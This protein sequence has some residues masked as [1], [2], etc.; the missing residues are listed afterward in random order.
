MP[1]SNDTTALW[2]K[3]LDAVELG[4]KHNREAVETCVI[5][6]KEASSTLSQH[7]STVEEAVK[8]KVAVERLQSE[9]K[10]LQ[11]ESKANKVGKDDLVWKVLVGFFA[12]VATGLGTALVSL[13]MNKGG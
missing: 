1:G 9:M 7:S 3:M 11:E 5:A 6:L 2:M 8:M 4:A 13:V 10:E 12:L